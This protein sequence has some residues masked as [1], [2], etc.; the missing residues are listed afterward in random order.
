MVTMEDCIR[1][2]SVDGELDSTPKYSVTEAAKISGLS[3]HT[4]RYYD[5]LGLFPFLQRTPGEKRLFSDADMQW[6]QLIEC[7]RNTGMPI[8]E[9]KHY[10]EL[11]LKGDETL[12]ERLKIVKN[13]EAIMKDQ[14]RE[15]RK[16]LKLLQFK[17]H[18]YEQK[19][20]NANNSFPCYD[21]QSTNTEK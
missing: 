20:S 10:V 16:H 4:L 9:V 15:M 2:I 1:S 7:L 19:I 13:Q 3:A 8:S 12:N 18:Y 14:I 5:D 6:I 11:C 17:K 21:T